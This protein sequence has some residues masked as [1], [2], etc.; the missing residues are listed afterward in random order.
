M[1]TA[2]AL[3]LLVLVAVLPALAAAAESAGFPD[4][5]WPV[6]GKVIDNDDGKR[7]STSAEGIDILVPEGTDVR[8]SRAGTVIY[9]GK[10]PESF[11]NLILIR[12][13]GGWITVYGHN[14]ELFVN[15]GEAVQAGDVIARSGSTGFVSRP[16][17]HFEI[18][19]EEAPRS[20]AEYLP[21]LKLQESDSP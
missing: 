18:R 10:G 9:A 6:E 4:F 16:M 21:L 13:E 14:G 17:L 11:G 7:G 3:T 20:P 1:V 8:A 2:Q 15:R 12:H 5:A 19:K